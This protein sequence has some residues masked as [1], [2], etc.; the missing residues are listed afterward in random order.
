MLAK[1]RTWENL[2]KWAAWSTK[3][4]VLETLVVSVVLPIGEGLFI[5]LWTGAKPE[6]RQPYGIALLALGYL[7]SALGR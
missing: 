2:K 1:N 4:S 5:N 6:E 3:I 7:F